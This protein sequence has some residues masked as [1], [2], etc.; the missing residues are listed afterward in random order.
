[1]REGRPRRDR[2]AHSRPNVSS[3]V[4]ALC[5]REDATFLAQGPQARAAP[6]RA[7]GVAGEGERPF[8]SALECVK[9]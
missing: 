5:A 3:A 2:P 8:P 4:D 7:G 6:P 1:M 9:E